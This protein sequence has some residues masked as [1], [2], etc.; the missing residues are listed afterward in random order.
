MTIAIID[1]GSGNLRSAQKAFEKMS[2][3]IP[4]LLTAKPDDVRAADRVVLPGQGAFADVMRGLTALPGMV[5]ALEE[6]VLKKARPFFG[7]CVGMQILAEKGYEHGEQTGLG[8]LP[9]AV[10]ALEPADPA[11]KIPHMG[12][13]TLNIT[14]PAHPLW[15]AIPADPSFYF[16]HSYAFT[17]GNPA[18][19]A[20]SCDYGNPFTA[21]ILKDNL[22]ATQFHPEKSQQNGLNLIANFLAWKP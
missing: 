10:R 7:I 18:Q 4:V 20:A 2:S 6:T 1:T 16:V 5:E 8:W 15:K 9:G 3:G 21:A 19:T 12:W 14:A 22:F 11:L 17:P 13:N